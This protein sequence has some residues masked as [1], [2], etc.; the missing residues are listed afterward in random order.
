MDHTSIPMS[1]N[2]RT[3]IDISE[4]NIRI[5]VPAELNGLRQNSVHSDIV[6]NGDPKQHDGQDG[7][8]QRA[9]QHGHVNHDSKVTKYSINSSASYAVNRYK[10]SPETN[11]SNLL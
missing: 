7:M 4:T 6:E 11:T 2:A 3:L 10:R 8:E 5:T 1:S 9:V